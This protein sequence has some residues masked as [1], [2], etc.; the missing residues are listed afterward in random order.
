MTQWSEEAN[1]NEVWGRTLLD[2][3]V[4]CGVRDVCICPGSRSTPLVVAASEDSR[5]RCHLQLDERSAG[6]FALGIGKAT[7]RPAAVIT[8]SGTAVANL[9]P[10]VVEA[11]RSEAPL[12]LL[13]ADRPRGVRE[14]DANQTADQV[15]LFG[16]HA[17]A[18]YDVPDARVEDGALR[19]LRA[20]ACRA[21]GEATGVPPGP[22]HVNIPFSPPLEPSTL[23]EALPEGFSDEH[24][25]AA[26]GR[27]DG[28]PYVQ[29]EPRGQEADRATVELLATRLQ[30]ADRPLVVAGPTNRPV[31][32]GAARRLARAL[33]L[34]LLADPLSGARFVASAEGPVLA[35]YDLYLRAPEVRAVLAPDLVVRVGRRPTSQAVEELIQEALGVEQIV[36]DPGGVWKDHPSAAS[37]YLRVE[38]APLLDAVRRTLEEDPGAEAA[39]RRGSTW[40]ESWRAAEEAARRSVRRAFMGEPFEGAVVH[41]VSAAVPAGGVLF[42][43]SSLP[44]RD[45]DAFGAVRELPLRAIGNRGASGIDGGVSTAVGAAVGS[46]HPVVAVL[47]DLSLFHDLNGLFSA[48]RE[49]APVIL[50]VINNDGGGL[51]HFLPIREHEPAFTPWFATPHGL[52]FSHAA[53]LHGLPFRQVE[54][55]GGP[56]GQEDADVLLPGLRRAVREA[57]HAGDPVVLEV[58]TD[59]EE[60]RQRR[61]EAV[62]QARDAAVRALD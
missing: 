61:L 44:V 11:N 49:G 25:L 3:L 20:L 29:V 52:D 5:I 4:R 33:S 41:E 21:Y 18:F 8:T 56:G 39:G 60:N 30:E 27:P 36:V 32:G 17:R 24:P 14:V 1:R 59:R 9:A 55:D 62:Q 22:V 19:R 54:L 26:L 12:L 46:G 31:D 58:R 53:R 38:P 7:E 6:F 13:T 28:T 42:I 34:P 15:H 51:F 57:V 43:G 37:R 47:G 10:A 23:D 48:A 2:E 16:R 45:L 35:R 40:G 50:V